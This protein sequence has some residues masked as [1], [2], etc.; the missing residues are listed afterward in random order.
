MFTETPLLLISD[1]VQLINNAILLV[2][3]IRQST[4]LSPKTTKSDEVVV[5]LSAICAMARF[6]ADLASSCA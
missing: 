6:P 1:R 2:D 3:L 5:N 4:E